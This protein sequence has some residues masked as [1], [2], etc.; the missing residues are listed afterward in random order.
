[1]TLLLLKCYASV[2]VIWTALCIVGI[3]NYSPCSAPKWLL[4]TVRLWIVHWFAALLLTIF[5][6][7]GGCPFLWSTVSW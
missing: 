1:V 5:G 6:A 4:W 3:C 7:I 2:L